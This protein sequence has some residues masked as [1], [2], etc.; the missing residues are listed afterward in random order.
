MAA[1]DGIITTEAQRARRSFCLSG[2]TDKQK[3][4]ALRPLWA[5]RDAQV[6]QGFEGSGN[7]LRTL[8]KGLDH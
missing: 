7:S 8:Y 6:A 4:S 3:C 1:Q 5:K 2:D